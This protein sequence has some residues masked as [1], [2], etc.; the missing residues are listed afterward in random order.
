M[1]KLFIIGNGFDC[2]CHEMKTHYKDFRRYILYR[3]PEIEYNGV[4]EKSLTC[5]HHDYAY[6][7]NEIIGYIVQVL[8]FCQGEEWSNLEFA[9]GEWIYCIFEE[10]F[11]CI[12]MEEDD[13]EIFRKAN[14]NEDTAIKIR[15]TFV[16]LKELFYDWVNNQLGS[17][18]YTRIQRRKKFIH[19]LKGLPIIDKL[20]HKNRFYIN[21]NYTFTLE[22][23]YGIK[24]NKVWHIHGKVG[25]SFDKIYFGHGDDDEIPENNV[26]WGAECA[27]GDIKQFFRKNTSQVIQNNEKKFQRLRNIKEIYSIGFSFSDVDMVYIDEICKYIRPSKVIWYFNQYDSQN[28]EEYIDKT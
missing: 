18:D 12:D 3:Y 13:N 6:Q 14:G 21:F 10:E 23:V 17:I 1:S 22:K 8:D 25:D 9:L 16:K 15:D 11:E 19:I 2:Y 4:P 24:A 20:L 28:N 7:E 26:T 27:L 5:D